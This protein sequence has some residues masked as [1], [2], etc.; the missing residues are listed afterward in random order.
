MHDRKTSTAKSS[1]FTRIKLN[2]MNN[3][4][5]KVGKHNNLPTTIGDGSYSI[6]DNKKCKLFDKSEK[7]SRLNLMFCL[8]ILSCL[9]F[10]LAINLFQ[11]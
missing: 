8:K 6:N 2:K 10:E 9:I 5:D 7:L 1:V 3:I 4:E 11:N